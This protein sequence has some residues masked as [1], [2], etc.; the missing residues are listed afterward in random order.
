MTFL[1]SSGVIP[2]SLGISPRIITPVCI[3][4]WNIP[5]SRVFPK[6]FDGLNR[7]VLSRLDIANQGAAY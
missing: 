5:K 1:D 4:G 3:S 6:A 7:F 2:G